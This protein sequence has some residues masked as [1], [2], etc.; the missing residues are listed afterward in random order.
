MSNIGYFIENKNGLL[1]IN[2]EITKQ[3]KAIKEQIDI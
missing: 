1:K 3:T 2:K